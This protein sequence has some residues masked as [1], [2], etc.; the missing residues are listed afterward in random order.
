MVQVRQLGGCLCRNGRRVERN[1]DAPCVDHPSRKTLCGLNAGAES[2]V[3]GFFFSLLVQL[4][5]RGRTKCSIWVP[6]AMF[7]STWRHM[8]K[9]H[10][11]RM[12]EAESST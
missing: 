6:S 4:A 5:L 7:K 10:L 8:E 1:F 11:D 2:I 3:W 12:R 9:R